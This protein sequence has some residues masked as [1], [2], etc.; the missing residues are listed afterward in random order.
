MNPAERE[1][2]ICFSL[3]LLLLDLDGVTI[4]VSHHQGFAESQP[5]VLIRNYA[6]GNK[7][8]PRAN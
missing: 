7:I 2:G 3:V 1:R 8:Y 6:R 4:W 5:V